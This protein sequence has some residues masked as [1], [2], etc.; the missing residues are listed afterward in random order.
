M[1]L[2]DPGTD[3]GLSRSKHVELLALVERLIEDYPEVAPGVVSRHVAA[4]CDELGEECDLD[5]V[6]R[7]AR[8]RLDTLFG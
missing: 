2:T 1:T 8:A 4:C 7:S 6:E 3:P 5:A